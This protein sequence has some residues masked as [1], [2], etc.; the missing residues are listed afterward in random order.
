MGVIS[1]QGRGTEHF[2]WGE[3]PGAGGSLWKE[4]GKAGMGEGG[5]E[6]AQEMGHGD[7]MTDGRR[8]ATGM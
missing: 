1:V 5:V 8:W 2:G 7:V 4:E 6:A 3:G